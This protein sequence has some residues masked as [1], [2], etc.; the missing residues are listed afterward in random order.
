L[1]LKINGTKVA[2]DG[3][4]ADIAST[5]WIAWDIDLA[6]VG[7]NLTKVTTLT[8]GVEGGETG[9]LYLDD[10]RLTRP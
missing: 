10:I 5:E 1:Y 3:A 9:L 6:S 2:Y 4:P 8:I 7:V